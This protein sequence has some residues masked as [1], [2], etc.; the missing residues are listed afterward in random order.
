MSGRSDLIYLYVTTTPKIQKRNVKP[1][2]YAQ[3]CIITSMS[4]KDRAAGQARDASECRTTA[5]GD[6]QSEGPSANDSDK[7]LNE[8]IISRISLFQNACEPCHHVE[9]C[10]NR[11]RHCSQRAA[12]RPGRA[13]K[14][15]VKTSLDLPALRSLGVITSNWHDSR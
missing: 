14:E 11:A 5:S 9:K 12:V 1:H 15:P 2:A 7:V 8:R 3:V 13:R 10:V 4:R 6:I